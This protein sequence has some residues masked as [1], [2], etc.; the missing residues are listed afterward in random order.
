MATSELHH[1]AAGQALAPRIKNL[2]ERATLFKI[3]SNAMINACTQY[4][5][6][7]QTQVGVREGG[8]E[9]TIF[10]YW[11]AMILSFACWINR[12]MF[13]ERNGSVFCPMRGSRDYG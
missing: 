4:L 13:R 12:F 2:N 11:A 9:Q 3:T 8:R 7:T 10:G 6:L 5:E 1:S